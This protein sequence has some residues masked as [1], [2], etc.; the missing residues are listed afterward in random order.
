MIATVAILTAAARKWKQLAHDWQA[1]LLG[2]LV[3]VV[4]SV[5]MSIPW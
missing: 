4:V 5:G 1:V 3:V 2:L